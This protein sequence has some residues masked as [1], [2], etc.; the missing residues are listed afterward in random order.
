MTLLQQV[1][2]GGDVHAQHVRVLRVRHL[3][4]VDERIH[5]WK[6]DLLCSS[7]DRSGNSGLLNCSG[8]N[9]GTII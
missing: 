8:A 4:L 9:L 6:S 1:V 7:D 2:Q 3:K 5:D